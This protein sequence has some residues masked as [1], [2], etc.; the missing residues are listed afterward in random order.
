MKIFSRIDG[1]VVIVAMQ[2]NKLSPAASRPDLTVRVVPLACNK[3][4]HQRCFATVC[5]ALSTAMPSALQGCLF[6]DSVLILWPSVRLALCLGAKHLRLL[7]HG[8]CLIGISAE[9]LP[10]LC[11]ASVMAGTALG[12]TVPQ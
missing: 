6:Y 8:N 12:Q 9:D 11:C 2:I 3:F 5:R 1:G 4:P 7:Q 10:Q